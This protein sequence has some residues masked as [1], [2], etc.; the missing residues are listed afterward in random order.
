MLGVDDDG[1]DTEA[2]TGPGCY[3]LD[4]GDE[5][6]ARSKIWIR[7]DYI[8]IYDRCEE[9]HNRMTHIRSIAPSVIITGQPGIGKTYW[10]R[11]ALR[12]RLAEQ[13]SV[14]WYREQ[15]CF[16]FAEDG[17]FVAPS[18]HRISKFKTFVWT[19]ADS[20]D[21]FPTHLINQDTKHF[22]LYTTSPRRERWKPLEKTTH[23]AVLIMN[24]WTRQEIFRAAPL[25]G[26]DAT[27]YR[28]IN[29]LYD[30]LG[31]TPRVCFDFLKN[32]YQLITHESDYDGVIS[33][34]TA[35]QL[36]RLVLN[37]TKLNLDAV[38]HL[39][40]LVKREDVNVLTQASV[41]PISTSVKSELLKRIQEE[42]RGA[43]IRLYKSLS[44][45]AG[46][47]P[48]AGL[49]F[50]SLAQAKLQTN[51]A[52]ELIPMVKRTSNESTDSNQGGQA[53][54]HSNHEKKGDNLPGGTQTT[55][56]RRTAAPWTKTSDRW[57][58]I[59]P[60]VTVIYQG[61]ELKV[62]Q[63]ST[64]YLPKS[65]NQVGFDSF[66]MEDGHLYIFQFS[67]ASTHPIKQG[68]VPF[69][70]QPSLPPKTK[71]HFIFVIPPDRKI[72]CPQPRDPELNKLLEEMKLFSA[73]LDPGI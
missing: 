63:P 73:E 61:S 60:K 33:S 47:G 4:F 22:L 12:R 36:C 23:S 31:P 19:L 45:V 26:L 25:H 2:E 28:R 62:I 5:N 27:H 7:K 17:V 52:L 14:I 21:T 68:I 10:I 11:Y 44:S 39:M 48:M 37:G 54:W 13:K 35:K 66:I 56:R 42:E 53:R 50:E 49:V 46:S 29:E 40:F 38:S 16:L 32:P 64:F 43:Q 65:P 72:S 18:N 8:R 9:F 57:V 70:S 1:E 59:S 3:P 58:K 51:V 71:W 34:L 69:F 24:P 41:A 20:D 6:Y 67:I 55:K 30:D 15:R